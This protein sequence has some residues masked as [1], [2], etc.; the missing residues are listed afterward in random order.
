[1]RL[2]DRAHF[3]VFTHCGESEKVGVSH[4]QTKPRDSSLQPS[5]SVWGRLFFHHVTAGYLRDVTGPWWRFHLPKKTTPLFMGFGVCWRCGLIHL[6]SV[7]ICLWIVDPYIYVFG[8]FDPVVW[9]RKPLRAKL[10]PQAMSPQMNAQMSA[11]MQVQMNAH[12]NAQMNTQMNAQV[13]P[14]EFGVFSNKFGLRYLKW[15]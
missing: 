7:A 14:S 1:M 4:S 3:A 11:Q 15:R 10:R 13:G 5:G 9:S 6:Q 12:M 2:H 8:D